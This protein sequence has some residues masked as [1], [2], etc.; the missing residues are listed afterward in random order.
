MRTIKHQYHDGQ[1]WVIKLSDGQE[2]THTLR[3]VAATLARRIITNRVQ[4]LKG[5][6][7]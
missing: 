3:T 2:V 5:R 1:R 6:E 4:F 7:V